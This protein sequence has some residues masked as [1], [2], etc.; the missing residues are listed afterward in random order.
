MAK[1]LMRNLSRRERQIMDIVYRDNEVTVADVR[2]RLPDPPGYSAVRALMRVLEEKGYLK[3]RSRGP[4][5]VYSPTIGRERAKTTALK[6]LLQTFFDDSA[7]GLVAAL[8]DLSGPKLS[9]EDFERL[10]RLIE[11]SRRESK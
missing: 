4:R 11:Q 6:H 2:A 1:K 3:H 5:Y 7:E 9:D 10:A 8:I